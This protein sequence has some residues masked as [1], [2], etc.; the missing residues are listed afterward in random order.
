MKQ[1]LMVVLTWA[2]AMSAF[3]RTYDQVTATGYLSIAVYRNFP[4][5]SYLDNGT[6]KGI[7]IELGKKIADQLGVRPQWFW[8]TADENL[9][10]DLRNAVWKGHYLGGGVADVMLRVPYAHDY[11]YMTNELGEIKNDMVVMFG[12][13]HQE[14]WTVVRNLSKLPELPN[15][16][17]F[18]YHKVGV[19]TDSVPDL[20]LTSTLRGQLAGMVNHFITTIDAVDALERQE[21]S[22]V[23]GMRGQIEWRLHESAD[24]DL[25]SQYAISD[26]SLVQWSRRTW[27]IGMAVRQ[28]NRQLSY[29]IE[30]IVEKMVKEGDMAAIFESY[31]MSYQMPETYRVASQ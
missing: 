14:G 24:K 29:A 21:V 9:D 18:R 11:A 23:V 8:V 28:N 20:T 5:Y 6:P 1:L 25:A 12:P 15:L 30:G 2:L 26:N 3:A 4:P 16:A 27:D 31:H 19:E 13:Y 7:D 10:D 17:Y 22:A